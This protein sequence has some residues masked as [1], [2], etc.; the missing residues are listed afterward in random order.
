MIK[1][2]NLDEAVEIRMYIQYNRKNNITK[3]WKYIERI[4]LF[5][6]CCVKIW[7]NCDHFE[8]TG[9]L[10]VRK[11]FKFYERLMKHFI[12]YD[13]KYRSIKVRK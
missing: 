3:N 11:Y 13:L 7:N 2:E 5:S 8:K 9:W 10:K 4:L 12:Y 1:C 6:Y